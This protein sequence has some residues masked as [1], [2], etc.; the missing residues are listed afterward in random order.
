M[1]MPDDRAKYRRT[2]LFLLRVWCVDPDPPADGD[3]DTPVGPLWQGRVQ[4]TV[5]GEGQDFTGQATLLAVLARM[6]DADRP[7]DRRPTKNPS[8]G[9]DHAGGGNT[10]RHTT[11]EGTP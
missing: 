11:D 10:G 7:E 6:L 4:R 3:T 9:A 1:P 2:N 5:S 8:A